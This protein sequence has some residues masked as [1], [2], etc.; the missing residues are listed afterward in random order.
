M[1]FRIEVEGYAPFEIDAEHSVLEAC[2]EAGVPMDSACGGFSACNACRVRVLEG[3][4]FC[5]DPLEEE[6]AF[7]EQDDQRLG[8]QLR[9]SGPVV[10]RLDSGM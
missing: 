3:R 5:G 6:R 10:L 9:V 1:R 8:C 7:L 4:Q 2:E